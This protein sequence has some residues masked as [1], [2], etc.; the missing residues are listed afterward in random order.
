M[1]KRVIFEIP[2][3]FPWRLLIWISRPLAF[4]GIRVH[5]RRDVMMGSRD[6]WAAV[7]KIGPVRAEVSFGG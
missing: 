6:G 5:L 2:A 4:I 1:G 3:P 7:Q